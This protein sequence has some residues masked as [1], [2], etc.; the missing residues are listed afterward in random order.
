MQQPSS[1]PG[2][3]PATPPLS[4]KE[5][6]A[7]LI[8]HYGYNEGFF[9]IGIQFN[10]VVGNVGPEASQIAPGAML[11][12]G[13]VG[14]S[15]CPPNSPLGVDASI[16]NPAIFAPAAAKKTARPKAPK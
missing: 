4:L 6:A 10:I 5:L 15:R 1:D 7:I 11:A 12:V 13:G 9:E 3:Q 8:K 14:L 2:V 16:V